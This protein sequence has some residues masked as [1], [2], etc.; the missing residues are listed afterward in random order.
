M[1]ETDELDEIMNREI[2]KEEINQDSAVKMDSNGGNMTTDLE[3]NNERPSVISSKPTDHK[4]TTRGRE[5]HQKNGKGQQN[6]GNWVLSGSSHAK[7]EQ[8]KAYDSFNLVKT[9]DK[10]LL[11][12]KRT[13]CETRFD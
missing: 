4:K 7:N 8:S 5:I 2:I 11:G 10:A 13:K 1:N 6:L 9:K 3:T 12:Q